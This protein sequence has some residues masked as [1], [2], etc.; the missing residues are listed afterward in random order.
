MSEKIDF[1]LVAPERLLLSEPVEMVVVPGSEGDFGALPR[2]AP[3]ITALRPGIV[4]VY[5]SGEVVER[6]FV[7]GGF[8]EVT[9][10]RLTVLAEEAI[11]LA[12][13]SVEV[14]SA[15]VRAAEEQVSEAATEFARSQA[16][17]ALTVAHAMQ[18]ALAQQR[19]H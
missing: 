6:I 15:R 12:E 9:E 18:A 11:P 4:D 5:Q 16:Q 17:H 14:V 2:H 19:P 8:A 1:E 13:L 3:M 7:S 10:S